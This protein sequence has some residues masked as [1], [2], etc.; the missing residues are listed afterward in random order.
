MSEKTKVWVRTSVLDIIVYGKNRTTTTRSIPLGGGPSDNYDDTATQYTSYSINSALTNLSNGTLS[1]NHLG[2]GCGELCKNWGWSR[3][4]IVNNQNEDSN[5]DGS[6]SKR[7]NL[8]LLSSAS[9]SSANESKQG[10]EEMIQIYITDQDSTHCNTEVT[11]PFHLTFTNGDLVMDNTY[12]DHHQEQYYFDDSDDEDQEDGDDYGYDDYNYGGG[13]G[14]GGDNHHDSRRGKPEDKYPDDLIT[15]TH[16]HEPSVVYCLRRRYAYDKIYTSTGPILIALNPFKNCSALYNEKIMKQ[17]WV[18]GEKQM[19]I[20]KGTAPSAASNNAKGDAKGGTTRTSTGENDIEDSK[21][22]PHVY[23][24]ADHSF[25]NMMTKLE[26]VKQQSQQ[27]SSGGGRRGPVSSSKNKNKTTCVNQSI[28]VSGE[29]G[30]GK[31]VTTKFIMQYLA[32]LSKRSSS[33]GGR[34]KSLTT[35]GSKTDIEQQVLQS[36][37]ILESFGNA[38]TIRNDNSS[39]FGKFIEIQFTDTGNLVGANVETYLLEKVRLVSQTE[40]ERNYHIF[41]EILQGMEDNDLEK[42]YLTEYTAVDFRMTNQSDTYDRRD[43]VSDYDTF[44]DLLGAMET[45]GF[46]SSEQDDI[47]T[48]TCA[49]LHASNLNL[50]SINAGDESEIDKTN[51]HLEPLTSLLGISADALNRA[52]C[53]FSITAGREKHT[54]SN[55]KEKAAKGLLALI[56]ATYGALFNYVVKRVNESITVEDTSVRGGRGKDLSKAAA[57]IGVLDIFG[58]ESFK[59]N[60][61]EQ[62]CINYCNET[63]Q[64]QFNMFVL[65]NEQDEY[66]KEGIQWSFISFP[67]NQDALDLIDK[68]GSGIL[69]ILDDQCRAP[70]TTDKTFINDIYQKLSRHNRFQANRRQIGSRKFAIVHYAGTVEYGS[71]GFVEKNRDDL[72]KEATELLLSSSN[73]FVQTL[74]NIINGPNAAANASRSRIPSKSSKLTVG[75]QFSRQLQELRQKIDNTLPHYVRCLKPNDELIPDHFD[76]LIV[77]DQLRCAGVIEAVR[78]SRVGYPQ[79]Y[80]HSRFVARYHI[81]GQSALKNAARSSRR[82]KPV[83]VLVEA[84]AIQMNE[85]DNGLGGTKKGSTIDLVSIGIQVGKTKVFLRRKAY[86]SL[87]MLRNRRMRDGAIKIQ[88]LGRRYIVKREYNQSKQAIITLQCFFRTIVACRIVGERRRQFNAT[89]I[90][91]TY[92]RFVAKRKYQAISRICVWTQKMHR[93]NAGRALYHRLNKERKAT[94]I[95]KSWRMFYLCKLFKMK[96]I[97]SLTL[98]CAWRCSKARKEFRALRMAARDHNNTAQE[99]DKLREENKK[100][101]KALVDALGKS[102]QMDSFEKE[103]E[104][105]LA[106]INDLEKKG[107][108]KENEMKNQQETINNLQQDLDLLERKCDEVSSNLVKAQHEAQGKIEDASKKH[109]LEMDTFNSKISD[110]EESL[111]KKSNEIKKNIIEIEQ[112]SKE[113]EEAEV[114]RKK[115]EDEMEAEALSKEQTRATELEVSLGKLENEKSHFLER[116]EELERTCETKEEEKNDLILKIECLSSLPQSSPSSEDNESLLKAAMDRATQAETRLETQHQ[117]LT[118]QITKLQDSCRAKE[119]EKETQRLTI[120]NLQEEV[121]RASERQIN[122]F[123]TLESKASEEM[124]KLI[125]GKETLSDTKSS[126]S[127]IPLLSLA[128]SDEEEEKDVRIATLESEVIELQSKLR[129]AEES[130]TEAQCPSSPTTKKK[131]KTSNSSLQKEVDR[132]K[133]KLAESKENSAEEILTL[134][135]EVERLNKELRSVKPHN[136]NNNAPPP[137]PAPLMEIPSGSSDLS[138]R[139]GSDAS[140]VM[141]GGEKHRYAEKLSKMVDALMAKDEEIRQLRQEIATLRDQ[142]DDA[143]MSMLSD[144]RFHDDMDDR[145]VISRI[146]TRPQPSSRSV[147]G[148][149]RSGRGGGMKDEKLVTLRKENLELKRELEG[150]KE[151]LEECRFELEDERERSGKELKAFADALKGVDELRHS[152]EA[153]SREIMRLRQQDDD[154]VPEDP[155]EEVQRDDDS[156]DGE[157]GAVVRMPKARRMSGTASSRSDHQSS[158]WSKMKLSVRSLNEEVIPEDS[159]YKSENS[160]D[161]SVFSSFF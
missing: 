9:T 159:T 109:K 25:R 24:T 47:M 114:M 57:S 30:A 127:N 22:P 31:T 156:P 5:G 141:T 3:G 134:Q 70:G 146:F 111:S 116:I 137:P 29:S 151:E 53:Y 74:G 69:S 120:K 20:M 88:S 54:R 18:Q 11:L 130:L 79:R 23:A 99:R 73:K 15:L 82:R 39:R 126:P 115:N 87:E 95:Q 45:M 90:Q 140:G 157:E 59:S 1:R 101:Q 65:K 8:K 105:L 27:G 132:L 78:V 93:G 125:G 44:Q 68:R 60:S 49:L 145:S 43:G 84:I 108:E 96:Q 71:K 63:L 144:S 41:Y 153:M 86:E 33:G 77:A 28:L 83:D 161:K 10:E 100:L 155:F 80:T 32:T 26:E 113:L 136:D 40:G 36:N 128:D 21:L 102:S 50:S 152:A 121:K 42:Y 154:D 38:R 129:E 37:P 122:H 17:Y 110:L 104:E 75:G 147:V 123:Q 119:E 103:R 48:V 35:S 106:K 6:S 131:K 7:N 66:E 91:T 56:K 85:A 72:P 148:S 133:K 19:A 97:A 4:Y 76:P 98:Q 58:F 124:D 34:R 16:L 160:E 94:V 118:S 61:F 62:L 67:D 139:E 135:D 55:S 89:K 81:L 150:V 14:G 117:E 112:L 64:Q 107:V 158:I 2:D 51:V 143:T 13:G 52:L 138:T 12:G 46:E 142:A 92:R 149:I